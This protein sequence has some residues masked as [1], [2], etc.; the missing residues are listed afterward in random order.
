[1]CQR[2]YEP[3]KCP[4]GMKKKEH[5]GNMLLQTLI[6]YQTTVQRVS[7]SGYSPSFVW[8][9]K[10]GRNGQYEAIVLYALSPFPHN[11]PLPQIIQK[12]IG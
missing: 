7:L 2:C 11:L 5:D 12:S 8:C 4:M 3:S 6:I 1:M 9:T 10:L